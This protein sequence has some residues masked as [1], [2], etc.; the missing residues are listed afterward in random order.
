MRQWQPRYTGSPYDIFSNTY[1]SGA[2]SSTSHDRQRGLRGGYPVSAPFGGWAAP[3][4]RPG[5]VRRGGA[6][7]ADEFPGADGDNPAEIPGGREH[8]RGGDEKWEPGAGHE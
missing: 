1:S 3:A 2:V 6:Q 4:V 5:E 7:Q 8:C